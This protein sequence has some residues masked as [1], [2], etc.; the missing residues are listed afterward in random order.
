MA[1]PK[2]SRIEVESTKKN[3]V[4]RK[5]FLGWLTSD[6]KEATYP[7]ER[8]SFLDGVINLADTAPAAVERGVITQPSVRKGLMVSDDQLRKSKPVY[9]ILKTIDIV[10]AQ[11]LSGS[12]IFGAIQNSGEQLRAAYKN[13]DSYFGN[14][15]GFV[16]I[17][18]GLI[19]RMGLFVTQIVAAA[20]RLPLAIASGMVG[21]VLGAYDAVTQELN[22]KQKQEGVSKLDLFMA[23]V[24]E[25]VMPFAPKAGNL[26]GVY[27]YWKKL[28]S[29][30]FESQDAT[31]ARTGLN[32]R[33]QRVEDVRT[34]LWVGAVS[35]ALAIGFVATVSVLSMGSGLAAVPFIPQIAAGIA[36]A[37]LAVKA[38]V[39]TMIVGGLTSFF[40]NTFTALKDN[41][42]A[43]MELGKKKSEGMKES[44]IPD[45]QE[46]SASGGNWS[47]QST[48]GEYTPAKT[49]PYQDKQRS[50]TSSPTGSE[51]GE[52]GKDKA[53]NRNSQKMN[54]I[55]G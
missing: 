4:I 30:Y 21:V 37:G 33:L 27:L 55:K 14:L 36:A 3:P 46:R 9:S 28:E 23:R 18:I 10:V 15:M 29:R 40:S 50:D 25:M 6:D 11:F 54:G 26:M 2:K 5:S 38:V 34:G 44:L 31:P 12:I 43:M 32:L 47:Y 53:G 1:S 41:A 51:L 13:D 39:A 35:T 22:V 42:K 24:G 16:G 7:L 19:G 45:R 20:I 49:Q 8:F 17:T 52:D 48:S